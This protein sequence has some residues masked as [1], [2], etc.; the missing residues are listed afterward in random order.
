MWPQ[1]KIKEDISADEDEE[2]EIE[3]DLS[4][5]D[6]HMVLNGEDLIKENGTEDQNGEDNLN[7]SFQP[8]IITDL[9]I[10]RSSTMKDLKDEQ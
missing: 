1:T 5:E 7:M 8:L 6:Q 9:L 3:A 10:G 4:K 2:E